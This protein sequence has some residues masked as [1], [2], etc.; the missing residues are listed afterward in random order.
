MSEREL[1]K[2]TV[3]FNTA[4]DKHFDKAKQILECLTKHDIPFKR[5]NPVGRESKVL[6]TMHIIS[7]IK[8]YEY[9]IELYPE[10]FV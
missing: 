3:D 1:I 4:M 2:G 8:D 6:N 10:D 7:N 9:L 5:T